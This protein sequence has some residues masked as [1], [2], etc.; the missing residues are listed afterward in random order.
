MKLLLIAVVICI[1]TSAEGKC[2][3]RYNGGYGGPGGANVFPGWTFNPS[4]NSCEQ[5]MVT[6]RCRPS[7]NCFP[8]KEKCQSDCD[9]WLLEL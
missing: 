1:H 4:T 5:V 3:P 2:Q 7:G 6:S 9:P 8:T